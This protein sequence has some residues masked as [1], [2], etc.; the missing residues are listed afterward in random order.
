MITMHI[1]RTFKLAAPDAIYFCLIL[2]CISAQPSL[3]LTTASSTYGDP[4][5]TQGDSVDTAL[6][7][8]VPIGSGPDAY[9]IPGTEVYE[10]STY[11]FKMS[12]PQGW[13]SKEPDANDLGMVVGFLAPGEN[14]DNPTSYV[15][16]QMEAL[17][18]DQQVTL[19]NY[20]SAITSSLKSAY[21]SSKLLSRRN[22][23]VS[24]IPGKEILYTMDD[25][26]TPYEILLQYTV[27]GDKAYVLSYYAP[28]VSY[29]QFEDGARA[30]IGSFQFS[31]AK[32]EPKTSIT[33]LMAPLPFSKRSD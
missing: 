15:T 8:T 19:D 20:T 3:A 7:L 18:P 11:G 10:N 6:A 4:D 27:Q 16:V 17:P 14:I 2:T 22:I 29:T 21:R 33:T 26:G 32:S 1:G 9:D 5:V 31:G 13:R 30:L 23:T 28:E 12:Y 24:G 25:G